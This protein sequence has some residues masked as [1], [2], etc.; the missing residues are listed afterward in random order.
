MFSPIKRIFSWICCFLPALMIAQLDLRAEEEIAWF[1][2][3][4]KQLEETGLMGDGLTDSLM[5]IFFTDNQFEQSLDGMANRYTE[6][7]WLTMKQGFLL[8]YLA[9]CK[10]YEVRLWVAANL[11]SLFDHQSM[12]ES[13]LSKVEFEEMKANFRDPGGLYG[14]FPGL[15]F[16]RYYGNGKDTG[17]ATKQEI[18]RSATILDS[19]ELLP[20]D[21]FEYLSETVRTQPAP[22]TDNVFR[23]I[24]RTISEAMEE[25]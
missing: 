11:D 6:E 24:S 7:E 4:G 15:R 19:L 16:S 22:E 1:E 17:R 9:E 21:M 2:S 25:D 12:E 5:V 20:A 8:S 13:G 3:K 10:D 23:W 14:S 18:L